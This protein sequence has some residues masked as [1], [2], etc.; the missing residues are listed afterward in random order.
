VPA[1]QAGA[2]EAA[3]RSGEVRVRGRFGKIRDAN[4]IGKAD[5]RG[6]EG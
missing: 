2:Q 1:T 6:I 3:L 4:H 5:P